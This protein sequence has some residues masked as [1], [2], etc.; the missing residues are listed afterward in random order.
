[1]KSL[2]VGIPHGS[3]MPDRVERLAKMLPQLP[4]K[5]YLLTNQEP[6][7]TELLPHLWKKAYESGADHALFLDDDAVLAPHFAEVL[8]KLIAA[9]PEA[10]LCL[11]SMSEYA[12]VCYELGHRWH[13]SSDLLCGVGYVMPRIAI[14]ELLSIGFDHPKRNRDAWVTAAAIFHKRPIWHPTPSIVDH[15]AVLPTVKKGQSLIQDPEAPPPIASAFGNATPPAT[16]FFGGPLK[17]FK[18]ACAR[19]DCRLVGY[20]GT[21]AHTLKN[22]H[23]HHLRVNV[24]PRAIDYAAKDTDPMLGDHYAAAGNLGSRAMLMSDTTDAWRSYGRRALF[25][26]ENPPIKAPASIHRAFLAREAAAGRKWI[27][28]RPIP[29]PHRW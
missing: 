9:R 3:H 2:F 23:A 26:Y 11:Y 7:R 25:V 20:V 1:M 10:I 4:A 22:P 28:G 12:P 5:P 13:A 8:P 24:D 6:K 21:H 17:A 29:D 27:G 19:A 18:I 16:C 15:P 14:G